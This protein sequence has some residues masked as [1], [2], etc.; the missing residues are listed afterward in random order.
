MKN[1]I[2]TKSPKEGDRYIPVSLALSKLILANVSQKVHKKKMHLIQF[3]SFYLLIIY[4][5]F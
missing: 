3:N 1:Q 5:S 2:S 4:Q